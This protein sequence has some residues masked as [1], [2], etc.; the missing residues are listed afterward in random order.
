MRKYLDRIQSQHANVLLIQ[1]GA[2]GN[3]WKH[4][5][6]MC[7]RNT[8]IEVFSESAILTPARPYFEIEINYLIGRQKG[9]A[10]V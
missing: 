5:P 4:I 6:Q 9:V 10:G 8:E 2:P 1:S 7:P 3:C